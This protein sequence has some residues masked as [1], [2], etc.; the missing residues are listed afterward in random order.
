MTAIS[1][2]MPEVVA[3]LLMLALNA[4]VLTGGA[5]FGGGVW[6]MLARGERADRH[7]KLIA[8]SIAPIWEANHVWL[9]V[10][11]V[12][13]FT[14]FPV[15]FGVLSV[16]LHIPLTLMLIGIVLRGTAFVFRAYGSPAAA[17][18]HRWGVLFAGASAFTPL[19]LG[20]IV[21][22]VAGG[23]IPLQP[24]GTFAN[25]FVRPWLSAFPLSV[26]VFALFLF[27][28]LAA[29]YLAVGAED[30]ALR[31]D[32]RKRALGAALG[33]WVS[34]A[35]TLAI[36]LAEAPDMP[37]ALLRARWAL[38]FQLA[39]AIAA[40]VAI[41]GLYRRRYRIARAAAAVQVSLILWGWAFA[42][43]PYV[44]PDELTIRDAAAPD[45]TLRLVLIGLAGGAIV[46][47]PSLRYLFRVFPTRS[48]TS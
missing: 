44:L 3:G 21:G 37:R 24:T 19:V 42:Q 4:Y 29:V 6:D 23:N 18:R 9:I 31:E 39:V 2:G 40:I 46:L 36:A 15:A 1:I 26:G 25:G 47:I 22:A 35:G 41:A 13:L 11:V 32:F 17:T 7:R 28:F 30:G 12:V 34:A 38:P 10:A 16:A 8:D 14:A 45:V 5:D 20:I 33:V 48:R 27:A 43:F